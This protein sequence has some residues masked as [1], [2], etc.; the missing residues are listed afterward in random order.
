M[1]HQLLT[2]AQI[3]EKAGIEGVKKD[4]VWKI[5]CKLGSV[6]EKVSLATS[7]HESK[8]FKASKLCQGIH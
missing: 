7:S 5:L 3:F 8:Y 4:K 6:K 2:N 1:K